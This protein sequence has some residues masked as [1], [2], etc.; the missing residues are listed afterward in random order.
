MQVPVHAVSQQTPSVQNPVLHWVAHEHASPL[1]LLP[2][3]S[4]P[5]VCASVRASEAL[6]WPPSVGFEPALPLHPPATAISSAAAAAHCAALG[7]SVR[8][9]V[10]ISSDVTAFHEIKHR[11][12]PGTGRVRRISSARCD[13]APLT[14]PR[15]SVAVTRVGHC[16]RLLL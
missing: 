15:A 1:A 8:S 7:V 13:T 9:K 16:A 6:S 11:K 3:P 12:S 5:Q 14:R 2:G 10:K 4:A